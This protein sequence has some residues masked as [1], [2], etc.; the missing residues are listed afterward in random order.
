MGEVSSNMCNP[1][2]IFGSLLTDTEEHFRLHRDS[3]SSSRDHES[4]SVHV[5]PDIKHN[6]TLSSDISRD[7]I[8]TFHNS[9]MGLAA[10]CPKAID[11]SASLN[12]S[13]LLIGH[14]QCC[15]GFVISKS[16][17]PRNHPTNCSIC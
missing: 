12:N 16:G 10:F 1:A 5:K 8:A 7:N 15:P 13:Q 6:V 17:K 3:T 2:D 11:D 4:P 9:T 14:D